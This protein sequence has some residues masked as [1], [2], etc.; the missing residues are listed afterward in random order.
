MNKTETQQVLD[1]LK[2]AYNDCE[3]DF[4]RDQKIDP[5]IAILD[6][7]LALVV[8]P[9]A[10]IE[11]KD[12]LRLSDELEA[13]RKAHWTHW[14][15]EENHVVAVSVRHLR[16]LANHNADAIPQEAASQ[17]S[18][19]VELSEAEVVRCISE[20]GCYGTVKM[21]Y[22]SGPYSIDRPSLNA[23]KFANAIIAAINA[24]VST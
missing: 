21:S 6:A 2:F 11:S 15:A 17:P 8:E 3:S 9:V 13:I 7:Y 18:T 4:V 19:A 16:L 14:A 12:A 22:E 20:S 5:A 10:C 1:A 24:K 23:T